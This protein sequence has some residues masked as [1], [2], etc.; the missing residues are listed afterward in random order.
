MSR[1]AGRAQVGTLPVGA[2]SGDHAGFC[3][4]HHF[5]FSRLLHESVHSPTDPLYCDIMF[6]PT[7]RLD[8]GAATS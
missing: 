7:P 8:R 4:N 1:A 3:P 5:L 6:L 2:L